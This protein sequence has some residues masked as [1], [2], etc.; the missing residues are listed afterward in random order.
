MCRYARDLMPVY[1]VLAGAKNTTLLRLDE[2]VN[3][4]KLRL[5]YMEDD[6]GNPGISAVHS[7]LK[8]SVF[9]TLGVLIE[10]VYANVVAKTWIQQFSNELAKRSI[11]VVKCQECAK[12]SIKMCNVQFAYIVQDYALCLQSSQ[13]RLLRALE[14]SYGLKAKK[15]SLRGF[16]HSGVIWS[17][18]MASERSARPFAEELKVK[19]FAVKPF[20]MQNPNISGVIFILFMCNANI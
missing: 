16:F 14:T 6:G 20:L 7:D 15:V 18:M 5:F 19:I 1:K 4:K 3:V 10:N 13:Q 2:P 12:A 9:S 8:V 17:H 11:K